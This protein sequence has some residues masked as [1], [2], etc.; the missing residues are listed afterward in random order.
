MKKLI[1]AIAAICIIAF[2]SCEKEDQ[3]GFSTNYNTLTASIE[4]TTQT[5]AQLAPGEQESDNVQVK[6]ADGDAISVLFKIENTIENIKYVLCSGIGSTTG[7]FEKQ[8]N[9]DLNNATF[10]AAVYPYK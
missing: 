8:G 2:T 10:I 4:N 9:T 5:K 6:W 1:Y 7:V 3:F